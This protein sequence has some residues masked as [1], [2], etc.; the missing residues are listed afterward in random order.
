[1]IEKLLHNP[2]LDKLRVI[3]IL[4]ADLNFLLKLVW[5]KQLV[6]HKSNLQSYHPAQHALPGHLAQSAVLNK[7]LT[8]DISCITRIPMVFM[9]NDA[10]ACYDCIVPPRVNIDNRSKGLPKSA[11][12]FFASALSTMKYKVRTGHGISEK[13]FTSNLSR[14]I[15][16]SCQGG[17]ASPPSWNNSLDNCLKSVKKKYTCFHIISPSG[18]KCDRLGDA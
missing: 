14:C 11:C 3:H 8:F 18:L 17:G 7:V 4:E 9:D 12:I 13:Y 6:R 1:M 15:L 2:R 5:G 16:G 10:T